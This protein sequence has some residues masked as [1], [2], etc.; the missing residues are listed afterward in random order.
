MSRSPIMLAT[1]ILV[2]SM[3][4]VQ[5]AR[6]L[7]AQEKEKPR[8]QEQELDA[9]IRDRRSGGLGLRLIRSIMDDVQYQIVPGEKNELRM[10]KKL[11]K[12]A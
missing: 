9:L 3:L 6:R 4:T 8:I 7:N 10:M 11:K 12:P 2:T 5:P 1:L